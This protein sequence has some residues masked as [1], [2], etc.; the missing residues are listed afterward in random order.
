MLDTFFH[1]PV[2]GEVV[3][4]RD[5][6]S[7][8]VLPGGGVRLPLQALP[9]RAHQLP[10]GHFTPGCGG[11]ELPRYELALPRAPSSADSRSDRLNVDTNVTSCRRLPGGAALQAVG[12][13]QRPAGAVRL[14]VLQELEQ[15]MHSTV[16]RAAPGPPNRPGQRSSQVR[17]EM[18]HQQT[19]LENLTGPILNSF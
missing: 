6:G 7:G 5:V 15:G 17:R 1:L 18:S 19:C 8:A 3:R 11:Q 14:G 4:E 9:A 2:S 16:C 10:A 12:E 13:E